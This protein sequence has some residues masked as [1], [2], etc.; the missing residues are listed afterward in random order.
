VTP[1]DRIHHLVTVPVQVGER[2]ACFVLDTGIGLT[3]L[4]ERLC[5]ELGCATG[6]S[7]FTGRRMSGQEVT[8]PLA[9]APPL[10]MGGMTRRDHVVGIIALDGFPPELGPV[11]GFLSLAFF[12]GAPFTVDYTRRAVI[13]ESP[14][15]VDERARDGSAVAVRLERDGPAIDAFMRLDVPGKGTVDVEI[16]MGSDSLIL[17]ERLAGPVGVDLRRDGVRRVEDRDETGHPY[18]RYFTRLAGS[19]HATGAPS[20]AQT[21]PE[22]MFQ[23]IIY[24]GLVGGA[25]LRRFTVTYDLPRERVVFGH[26][27]ATDSTIDR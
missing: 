5:A 18:T 17:D 15:S 11:D 13:V 21:D 14:A 25:F 10:A 19:I 20:V 7:T 16:D 26:G 1:F 6:G 9:T 24:D 8:V 4:S 22:V 27:E 2:T 23:R 3:L 12:D